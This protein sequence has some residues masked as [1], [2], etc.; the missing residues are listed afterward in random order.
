[1]VLQNNS[2]S[3]SA[4]AA[5]K[6]L[7][8]VG[9]TI[10]NGQE[11]SRQSVFDFIP[12]LLS[13]DG[14]NRH[15]KIIDEEDDFDEIDHAALDEQDDGE[16]YDDDRESHPSYGGGQNHNVSN[17]MMRGKQGKTR[18]KQPYVRFIGLFESVS[19]SDHLI[20]TYSLTRYFI[21]KTM[22]TKRKTKRNTK[23]KRKDLQVVWA[24]CPEKEEKDQ[25][26]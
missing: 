21:M 18:S 19:F 17:G 20:S 26:D 6:T 23:M 15:G 12:Q 24:K 4:A 5:E 1:L 8:T 13:V 14:V 2:N 3:S 22:K 9:K 7:E 16:E 25:R 10:I 11:I